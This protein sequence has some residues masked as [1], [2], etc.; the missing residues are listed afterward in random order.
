MSNSKLVKFSDEL[1]NLIYTDRKY[2]LGKILTCVESSMQDAE[3]RKAMKNIITEIYWKDFNRFHSIHCKV[4]GFLAKNTE[5]IK[6]DEELN[7]FIRK[8]LMSPP[9]LEDYKIAYDDAQPA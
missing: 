5:L 3:Q 9:S 6:T 4:A 1:Q 8:S 7:K 2:L